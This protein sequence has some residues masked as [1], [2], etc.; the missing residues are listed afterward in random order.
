MRTRAVLMGAFGLALGVVFARS[1]VVLGSF[2][3]ALREY[4]ALVRAHAR[5]DDALARAT[6]ATVDLETGVRGFALTRDARFLEPYERAA[7]GLG[8][9]LDG[10]ERHAPGGDEGRA[11]AARVRRGLEGWQDAVARPLLAG[12][13]AEA[14]AGLHLEG[15]RRVDAVRGELEALR[16]LVAADRAGEA[17]S[18]RAF[19]QRFAG[20]AWTVSGVTAALMV[21]FWL[22]LQRKLDAPLARLARYAEGKEGASA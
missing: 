15:K 11:A 12:A 3:D 16:A 8:A 5:S 1:F 22:F 21:A 14:E 2:R 4:D 13:A 17:A 7:A 6:A 10:L 18:V 19:E 9:T 20:E